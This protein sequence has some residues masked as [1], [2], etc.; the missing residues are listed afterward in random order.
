MKII[1][2]VFLKSLMLISYNISRVFKRKGSY[3]WDLLIVGKTEKMT[4]EEEYLIRKLNKTNIVYKY[5]KTT[6]RKS[7]LQKIISYVRFSFILP[8]TRNVIVYDFCMP[9]Y[10]VPKQKEALYFQ[11]WH[12]NGILKDYG[13]SHF[14]KKH[15]E[16]IAKKL[17]NIVPIHS[18][19]D[20]ICVSSD[21]C[22]P[23]IKKAF[24]CKDDQKFIVTNNASIEIL[25]E[26]KGKLCYNKESNTIRVLIA[27][28]HDLYEQTNSIYS[29][30]SESLTSLSK[31]KGI[32]IDI[33]TLIHPLLAKSPA[34]K[35]EQ[36]CNAD[37][38]VTDFSTVCFEAEA[39]GCKVAFLRGAEYGDIGLFYDVAEKVYKIPSDLAKDILE[40]KLIDNKL[41]EYISKN[42][43]P[44]M[45]EIV[46]ETIVHNCVK[47][48]SSSLN[49][50]IRRQYSNS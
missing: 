28:S 29:E 32:S 14:T 27:Q 12:S 13:M 1:L 18:S 35:I 15:G 4:M 21:N 47:S 34:D 48:K 49:E 30:L 11:L 24:N 33:Q 50:V 3:M 8:H 6:E 43:R 41:G 23:Y 10:A 19:Y 31:E 16:K 26:E 37:V 17:Y 46:I 36:L 44:K 9:L 42:D 5:N 20:Y 38:L 2:L 39:V 22:I 40:N 25:N 7:L 45:S